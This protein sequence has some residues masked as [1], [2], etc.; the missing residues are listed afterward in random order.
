MKVDVQL[1]GTRVDM[2]EGS[3]IGQERELKKYKETIVQLLKYTSRHLR[4]I[5]RY[6]KL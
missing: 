2:H 1:N 6:D 4:N 5:F 3:G